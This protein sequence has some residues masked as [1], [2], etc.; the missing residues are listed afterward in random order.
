MTILA[1]L[2]IAFSDWC[3]KGKEPAP[4]KNKGLEATMS[5]SRVENSIKNI[6]SGAVARV[7]LILL[8]F[9][10]RTV[11]IH[12]LGNEYLSINGLYS[13]I[14]GM[15]SLAELGFGTAMVYNMYQPLAEKNDRKLA[16]LLRL[17][18]KVYRVVGSCIL[19]LGVAL[20]PF[21]DAIIK[22]PPNVEH[23]TIYYLMYLGNSVLSYWFWSY[24]CAILTADQK[25]YIRT[26]LRTILNITKAA[27]QIIV[28]VWLRN[29]AFYL[30]IQ[31]A[32]TIFENMLSAR[33]AEK[34]YGAF[35]VQEEEPLTE[36]ELRQIAKDVKSLAV[37][38][39]GHVAL[40]STDNIIIA[41][42]IG[43]S[44]IGLLSNYQMIVETVTGVLC[45]FTG[46]LTASLGNY[47]AEK[48]REEGIILF[49]RI[50]FINFWLYGICA[51][52]LVVLLDPFVFLWLGE[53]YMLPFSVVL[54]IVINFFV[55]GYMNV[56]WTFRSAMGLFSQGW[57]RSLIVAVINIA[58]SIL[59]GK[60]W[61]VFGV[62]IATFV[63]NA[64]IRLWFDPIIIYKHGFD[65]SARD[66]LV[67]CIQR[68][69]QITGIAFL[70]L[71]I[72]PLI[73][74]ENVTV[75]NFAV[76]TLLT[77]V[78][79]VVGFCVLNHKKDEFQYIK[80]VAGNILSKLMPRHG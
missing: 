25:E 13:N 55:Q 46:S 18:R 32:A 30:V 50:E 7:V 76:L 54:A 27:I 9:A 68:V 77:A 4:T 34:M 67:C 29:F 6:I 75:I 14:L 49:R 57:Y 22:D 73:I 61:G 23:L 19:V 8:N 35:H 37:T 15:L 63:A 33:R 78:V 20:V 56:L 44:W 10:V 48:G 2:H 52:A 16:A 26:N 1:R 62:L 60:C 51:I 59:L 71:M 72:R 40:Y 42:L 79:S 80:Y 36:T 5:S 65:I 24:K 70:L 39:L 69:I 3:L 17:Y 28:L 64:V 11:F 43:V 47:F 41:A 45:L 66:Y 53:L 74:Q 12:T 21:L 38:R 31:L 58:L